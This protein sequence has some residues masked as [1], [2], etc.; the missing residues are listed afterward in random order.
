MS[1]L[2]GVAGLMICVGSALTAALYTALIYGLPKHR[3]AG[4]VTA[5]A[6]LATGAT[7][8]LMWFPV[9]PFEAM[10]LILL[11]GG[12]GITWSTLFVTKRLL[13]PNNALERPNG[14]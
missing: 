2:G 9:E 12:G 7:I 4:A 10:F 5:A 3:L 8:V 11:V 6:I 1:L 14:N 13:A